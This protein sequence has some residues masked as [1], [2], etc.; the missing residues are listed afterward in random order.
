MSQ[1]NKQLDNLFDKCDDNVVELKNNDFAVNGIGE[2]IVA[3]PNFRGKEGLIMFY[4]PWCNFCKSKQSMWCNLAMIN[5][6]QFVIGALNCDKNQEFAQYSH[7]NKY[8][9]FKLVHKDG[10]MTS[11][12]HPTT[13]DGIQKFIC[14]STQKCSF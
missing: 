1:Y 2:I 7:V 10:T 4:A 13:F 12:T 11:Y 6:T 9:T 5:G 14:Q 3:H 8:P